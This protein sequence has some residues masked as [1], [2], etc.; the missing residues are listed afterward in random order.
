MLINLQYKVTLQFMKAKLKKS[1]PGTLGEKHPCSLAL[2]LPS[3]SV[4][5]CVAVKPVCGLCLHPGAGLVLPGPLS[6]SG[7]NTP[8]EVT[9]QSR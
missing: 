4:P 2:S 6:R 5:C 9:A 8:G 7:F 3:C 1:S